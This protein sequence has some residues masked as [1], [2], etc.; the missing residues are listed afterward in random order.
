MT[1][2]SVKVACFVIGMHDGLIGVR[3]Q[4]T[5][6]V[7]VHTQKTDNRFHLILTEQLADI[8]DAQ[9]TRHCI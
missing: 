9:V 6:S 7:G 5:D 3:T 2:S 8:Y 1:Y 4:K